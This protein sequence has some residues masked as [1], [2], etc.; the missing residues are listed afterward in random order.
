MMMDYVDCGAVGGMLPQCRFV[1][2]KPHMARS[3]LER[4]PATSRLSYGTTKFRFF[5]MIKLLY[6]AMELRYV[7][8]TIRLEFIEYDFLT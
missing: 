7:S 4:G 2:Q 5:Q 1:H 8:C 3:G 6:L